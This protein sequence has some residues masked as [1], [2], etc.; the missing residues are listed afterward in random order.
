MAILKKVFCKTCGGIFFRENGRYNEAEKFGWNQYCSKECLCH[1]RVKKQIVVCEN[2]GKSFQR[3]PH[4]IFEHNFCCQSCAAVV[5]NKRYSRKHLIPKLEVC[6]RCDKQ[7]KKSSGNIK[8]CSM[9]CR[10]E[11]DFHS[12][13]DILDVLKRAVEKNGRVPARRELRGISSACQRFFGSWNKAVIAAGFIPNRSD[14]QRMYR[15]TRTKA[16]DGHLCD[17][18]SEALI[19][20]WLFAH[21]ISHQRDVIYPSTK[22][23]ADWSVNINGQRVFIE[24]FGLARDSARYDRDMNKKREFC[25][26][27]K[28]PLIEIYPRD[29][30]PEKHLIDKLWVLLS[31]CPGSNRG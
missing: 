1:D 25:R 29:L 8:Y 7:F 2:C 30:Y 3:P 27:N 21:N 4:E 5:N 10:K 12:V 13:G 18:I 17:S 28:I 15:R 24:Y 9:K 14:S 11:A 6:I 23:R 31:G 22:H 26:I 19:D 16:S 20:N